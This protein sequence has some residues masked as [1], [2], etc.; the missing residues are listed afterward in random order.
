MASGYVHV[1]LHIKMDDQRTM[2]KVYKLLG[3]QRESTRH[4]LI[5][6][7]W[8]EMLHREYNYFVTPEKEEQKER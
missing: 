4:S 5:L 2:H 7:H 1:V 8:K 6:L 3:E